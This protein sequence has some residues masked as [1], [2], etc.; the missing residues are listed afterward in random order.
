VNEAGATLML[1]KKIDVDGS[2]VFC[3]E[4]GAHGRGHSDIRIEIDFVTEL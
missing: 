4:G 3:R 2:K 1:S